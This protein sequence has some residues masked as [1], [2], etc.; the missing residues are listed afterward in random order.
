MKILIKYTAL[1]ATFILTACSTQT[2]YDYSA[3][4]ESQ[5]R[6]IL[7]L[8]PSNSSTEVKAAPA[9]L[10]HITAPLAEAGYYVFPPAVVY[11]TFKH[12]GLTEGE[13]I[14]KVSLQKLR[15]VFNADSVLY[16]HV[17]DYGSQY[18]VFDSVTYVSVKGTLVDL[19]TGKTLWTGD[20][21]ADDRNNNYS[22]NALEQLITAAVKQIIDNIN[23]KGFRVAE[24][25]DSNLIRAGYNGGLLYGPYH[26]SYGKDPQLEKANH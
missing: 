25:A 14:Q 19:R 10:S 23:D 8:M 3:L 1:I 21:Y 18:Q 15:Q 24:Y 13:E 5:P 9:V 17:S 7:V 6:S 12:N 20:G 2:P 22:G 11:E 26:P 4:Q 16:L